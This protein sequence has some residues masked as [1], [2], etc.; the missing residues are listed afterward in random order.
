MRSPTQGFTLIEL[1]IVIAILGIIFT[2]VITSFRDIQMRQALEFST[3][4]VRQMIELARSRTLAAT[5]DNRHGVFIGTTRVVL[6]EGSTYN[7][8]AATNVVFELDRRVRISNVSLTPPANTI[9]FT[10]GT[11]EPSSS[12]TIELSLIANPAS[13]MT[14]T[15]TSTG[16]V[17]SL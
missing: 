17:R 9:V 12:G 6:F 3:R 1:L 10:R 5:N 8:H 4:E 2:I 16:I 7:E 15:I 13:R 14:I 11:G